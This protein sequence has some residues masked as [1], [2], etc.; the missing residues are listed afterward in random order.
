MIFILS[1]TRTQDKRKKPHP[2]AE[3]IPADMDL[4]SQYGWQ[5][6]SSTWIIEIKDLE[7]LVAFVDGIKSEVVIMNP[8]S[9]ELDGKSIPEIEIYNYWRE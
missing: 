5:K 8:S 4:G 2:R 6:K 1:E 9:Y 3:R 7:D